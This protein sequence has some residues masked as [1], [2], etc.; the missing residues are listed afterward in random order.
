L[1]INFILPFTNLTGGIRVML[2]YANELIL[3]GHD[4]VCY[5]PMIAYKFNSCGLKGSIRQ[6]KAS[7]GNIIKSGINIQKFNLDIPIK[8]VPTINDLFIPDSDVVVATAWPTAYSVNKLSPKKGVKYYFIQ[9]YEVWSGPKDVVDQSY[10]LPLRRIVIAQWLREFI[11]KEFQV[12]CI[13]TVPNGL[14]QDNYYND[15]KKFN[16]EKTIMMM[17][18]KLELKGYSD[19][20]KA[21]EIAK[22][23]FPNLRLRLFGMEW[24]KD[25]PA[26]AEFYQNPSREL[27]RELY[28]TSDIFIFPSRYEGWG[29]TPMEAM[30]CKCAVVA[31][32]VGC[33]QDIGT[34]R[35]TAMVSEP[36]NVEGLAK[37]LVELLRDFELMKKI[38]YGGYEKSLKL[39]LNSSVDVLEQVFMGK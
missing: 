15:E 38:G 14:T 27:L 31:T 33:I 39:T 36:N 35:E 13:A 9:G 16:N 17:Y 25:I 21:F 10:R 29:L 5:V 18:H 34:H 1:R 3:R 7:G 12:G 19:G 37:N 6:L 26:Y 20:L 23:Q 8:L 30:A 11:E 24:G 22:E 32:N 4:V 28:Y 2:K